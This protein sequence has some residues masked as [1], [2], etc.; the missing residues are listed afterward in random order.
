M[1]AV[2]TAI[3]MM[4]ETTACITTTVEEW[5]T[6]TATDTGVAVYGYRMSDSTKAHD[7]AG[8]DTA[9]VIVNTTDLTEYERT[10]AAR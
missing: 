1:A 5:T 7:I 6:I 2:V 8:G 4:A 3:A 10:R 9:I